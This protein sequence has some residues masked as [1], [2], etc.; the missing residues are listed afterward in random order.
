MSAHWVHSKN[1]LFC[2]FLASIALGGVSSYRR[3]QA[4]ALAPVGHG[5]LA[6][7]RLPAV[8]SPDETVRNLPE[9]KQVEEA[10]HRRDC[11]A[12]CHMLSVLAKSPKL[13]ADERNFC[14]KEI[15]RV[16]LCPTP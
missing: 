10:Y 16:R 7:A 6:S 11:R 4:M 13:T 1:F 8:A 14:Q 5:S 2:A 9:Y 15:W 3:Q 12:A